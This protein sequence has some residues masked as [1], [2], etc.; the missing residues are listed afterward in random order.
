MK[1]LNNPPPYPP[2]VIVH[3]VLQR[4]FPRHP[5]GAKMKKV[6][7]IVGNGSMMQVRGVS[8]LIHAVMLTA[9]LLLL[10]VAVQLTISQ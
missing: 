1:T 5:I 7:A 8:R 10:S 3:N 9:V 2:S 6:P 4:L